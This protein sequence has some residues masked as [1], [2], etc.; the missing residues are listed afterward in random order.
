[1]RTMTMGCAVILLLASCA[2][3]ADEGGEVPEAGGGGGKADDVSRTS[4]PFD[5]QSCTGA[6]MTFEDAVALF[7]PGATKATIGEYVVQRRA[8]PCNSVTG[9]GAWGATTT[10]LGMSLGSLGFDMEMRGAVGLEVEGG[11]IIVKL[12]DGSWEG[13]GSDCGIVAGANQACSAYTYVV[14]TQWG[15][16]GGLFPT[17]STVVTAVDGS[18]RTLDLSG[19]MTASCLRFRELVRGTDVEEEYVV[20]SRFTDPVT[21]E[22]PVCPAGSYEAECGS[23]AEP[24]LTTCCNIGLV[25]CPQ[26][27]C[28]CWGSCG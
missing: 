13:A 24:G 18:E 15:G 12:E 9:C 22:E 14:G 16:S 8:R 17:W 20:L 28:D 5:P 1:M 2:A 6:A 23:L 11:Q 3:P 25:T 26:S 10:L 4:D 19:T 27:G 21:P 7:E